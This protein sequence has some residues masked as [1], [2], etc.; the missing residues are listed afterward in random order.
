MS[1]ML[2]T[3]AAWL[4]ESDL[5]SARERVPMVYVD[6]VP[7]RTDERGQV[8]TV[9]LLLRGLPDG[10]ISRAV[11][12]GRVMYGERVR[13]AL[14]RHLEKDLGAMALPQVPTSP[15]PFTIV[16]YFPDEAVTGFTTA[17]ACSR[18]CLRRSDRRRLRPESRRSRLG[19][20][21]APG[22]HHAPPSA[23]DEWRPGSADRMALAH[24]GQLP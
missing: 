19:L 16:E 10:S 5:E 8:T 21:D 11:V 13:D 1:D 14:L 23:G 20:G 18:R 22:G 12:S 24:S 6:A 9:G 15:Q 3:R 4:S 17:R 2:D 7:V